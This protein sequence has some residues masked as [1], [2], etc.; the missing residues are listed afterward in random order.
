MLTRA[1]VDLATRQGAPSVGL[2][3]TDGNNNARTMYQRLG[4]EFTG[5]WAPLPHDAATGEHGMRIVLGQ[6][7]E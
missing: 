2:W 1:V 6:G 7:Q 3:V 4:F 5:E